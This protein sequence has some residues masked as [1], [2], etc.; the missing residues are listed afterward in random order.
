MPEQGKHTNVPN[1]RLT[2]LGSLEEQSAQRLLAVNFDI[3]RMPSSGLSCILRLG[4]W[5]KEEEVRRAIR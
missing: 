1:V 4:A 2:V 5:G 3:L